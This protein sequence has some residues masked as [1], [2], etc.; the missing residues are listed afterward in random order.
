[1]DI[2]DD[3]LR[4]PCLSVEGESR[5]KLNAEPFLRERFC[6]E[7]Q[8]VCSEVS[9]GFANARIHLRPCLYIIRYMVRNAKNISP[10]SMGISDFLLISWVIRREDYRL[11]L[12]DFCMYNKGYLSLRGE[13]KADAYRFAEIT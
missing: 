3:P 8:R 7:V 10:G 6:A 2:S 13:E 9:L 11:H 1:M 12:D 5:C 4:E